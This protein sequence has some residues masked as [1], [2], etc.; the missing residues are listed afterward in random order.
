MKV[1]QVL[2]MLLNISIVLS[3]PHDFQFLKDQ[4]I[5]LL[6]YAISGI[7]TFMYLNNSKDYDLYNFE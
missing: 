4:N 6:F 5:W 2:A 3:A 1:H 7:S